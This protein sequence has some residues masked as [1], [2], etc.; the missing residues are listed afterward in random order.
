M[1][2]VTFGALIAAGIVL[3]GGTALAA[4]PSPSARQDPRAVIDMIADGAGFV[5]LE[6]RGDDEPA[7]RRTGIGFRYWRGPCM[8][9]WQGAGRDAGVIHWTDIVSADLDGARNLVLTS[10]GGRGSL[11]LAFAPAIV[12]HDRAAAATAARDIA[13]GCAAGKRED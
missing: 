2:S 11:T 10:G 6:E 4:P 9:Y 8:L 13:A 12:E 5:A 1:R 7:R 3:W